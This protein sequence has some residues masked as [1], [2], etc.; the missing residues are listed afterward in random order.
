MK[1]T[2]KR[3]FTIVE[4]VIVIA[5]IAILAAVLI[6]TFSSLVKKANL[7]ADEQAVKQMN[8]ALAIYTAENSKPKNI[9]EVK[10][11][12]DQNG[13]NTGSLETVSQGYAFFWNPE[14]NTIVLVGGKVEAKGT[15]DCLVQNGYCTEVN[16]SDA[17]GLET[18]LAAKEN[19]TP[20]LVT[21]NS[22]IALE[23]GLTVSSGANVA[24]NLNGKKL[25]HTTDSIKPTIGD[26]ATQAV[27]LVN[28]GTLTLKNGTLD[29]AGTG[30]VR[31]L[32][33]DVTLQNIEI[34]S[35]SG[36]S[37]NDSNNERV[38]VSPIHVD[39]LSTT[40]II[41]C[42]IESANGFCIGTNSAE[43][44]SDGAILYIEESDISSTA[45]T[46]AGIDITI[47]AD[48]TIKGG[49]ISGDQT[50]IFLRGCKATIEGTT[51]QATNA[52]NKG[53]EPWTNGNS[54]PV[55]DIV[56]ACGGTTEWKGY[57]NNGTYIC[58]NVKADTVIVHEPTGGS[59]TVSGIDV[60]HTCHGAYESTCTGSED[61]CAGANTKN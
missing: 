46:Y 44:A 42:K 4:L 33:G 61:S 27:F 12:L 39:S 21:L 2:N 56:F 59:V 55:A 24:I 43:A 16:V 25:S 11:A 22:D 29:C 32:G 5:V 50:G 19:G 58:S 18:A 47:W 53:G 60:T 48:V 23:K 8:T 7:S 10:T 38:Q 54:G 17:S 37:G 41:G 20:V 3:G 49:T 13:I 31:N 1:R 6:P 14:D 15:W 51:V 52:S 34:P 40:K 35:T 26:Q 57:T 36:F 45:E 30:G 28:G 9:T